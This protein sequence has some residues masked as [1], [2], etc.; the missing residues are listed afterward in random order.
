MDITDKLD[1]S[2]PTFGLLPKETASLKEIIEALHAI[3][4]QQT[5][6]E[7]KESSPE[8]E[9]WI[10]RRIESPQFQQELTDEQRLL[11]LKN[12][13]RSELFESFLHTKY[14]GQKR[15]SLEGAETLISM[16]SL[17]LETGANDSLQEVVI[18]MA[19]RGRLNVL[20][21]I[22]NKSYH[23]ILSEFEEGYVPDP[24]EGMGDVKY[25]KGFAGDYTTGSGKKIAVTLSPNPSHL[26]SVSPVVEGQARAKQFLKN[27]E[28]DRNRIMPILIHGDA[29]VCGQ[30]VV[31]ETLQ[32]SQLTGY[33]TGGLSILSLIIRLALQLFN[34]IYVQLATLHP[35]AAPLGFLPFMSMPKILK[36]V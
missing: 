26:E 4:C 15:F 11:I 36:A 6:F 10:Q 23:D 24:S 34:E 32:F 12:L 35:L 20:A 7:Y 22:M 17:L 21:N 16:L 29:A 9:Q 31:Y 27:D 5:G 13:N 33:K 28:V 25:H 3:Y 2:F 30:G 1:K 18:G 14:T 8:M 19:H